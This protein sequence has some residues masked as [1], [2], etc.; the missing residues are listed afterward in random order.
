MV[1]KYGEYDSTAFAERTCR[2][3][4]N[5]EAH[6]H[7]LYGCKRNV[8]RRLVATFDSEPQLKSYVR[9]ATLESQGDR[10]GKFEQCSA[11]AGYDRWESSAESLT[12]DDAQ[13]VLHNPS[14]NML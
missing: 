4:H 2:T 13:A 1:R 6:M 3:K 7:Y 11:L 8:S 12:D 9:W 14:P 10:Q 5:Q